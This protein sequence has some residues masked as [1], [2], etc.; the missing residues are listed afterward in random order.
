LNPSFPIPINPARLWTLADSIQEHGL[1]QP[2]VVTQQG[3]GYQLIAGERRWQAAKLA[4]LA[5]VPALVKDATPQQ[6][7][8]LALVEN[9]QRA[10]LTPLEEAA[11]YQELIE[12]F[13]LTQIQVAK[14]VGKSRAAVAN[15][16]RLLRLPQEV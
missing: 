7:I 12:D 8:E 13:G 16:I 5:R 15:S 4:G 2:L 1:I 10:D 14:R 6:M 11:A 9:I 3:Q